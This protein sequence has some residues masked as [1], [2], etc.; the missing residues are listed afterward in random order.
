MQKHEY[1]KQ[2]KINTQEHIYTQEHNPIIRSLKTGKTNL[3]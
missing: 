1:A 2:K 3:W